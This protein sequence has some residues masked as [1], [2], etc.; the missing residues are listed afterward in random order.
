MKIL[1]TKSLTKVYQENGNQVVA[2]EDINLGFEQGEFSAVVGPSG[3]GKTTFLNMVGGIDKPTSGEIVID[4]TNIT[5][6]KDSELIDFRLSG[7]LLWAPGRAWSSCS[8]RT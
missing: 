3:S 8:S 7:P 6:L 4:G 2:L 5:S 1:E